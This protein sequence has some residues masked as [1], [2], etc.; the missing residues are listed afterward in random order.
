MTINW[1]EALVTEIAERRCVVVIGAGVSASATSEGGASPP[2]WESFLRGGASRLNDEQRGQAK[3]LIDE[4]RFVDA[5]EVIGAHVVPADFDRLVRTTL[6]D[7]RY[8]P[9]EWHRLIQRLDAKVVISL[10][11]D[12]ILDRQCVTGAGAQA[13]NIV[14]YYDTHL[15]ND[16]RSDKRLIVKAHGCVSAPSKIVLTRRSYF[17]ARQNH[18]SFY[19]VLDAIFLTSTLLFLGCGFNEDPDI[20]LTLENATIA[21]H[22]DHTHYAM[23]SPARPNAVLSA[24][25]STFNVRFLSYAPGAHAE[26]LAALRDLVDRVDAERYRRSG[27]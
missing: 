9:S 27:I 26:G 22:C 18:P 2:G 1:P 15:L 6:V 4:G 3:A 24:M 8:Q 16:L 25:E 13:Y 11:Y 12:D 23:L 21:A 17:A 14:R 7:P 10:N 20:Q 5:A 19:S